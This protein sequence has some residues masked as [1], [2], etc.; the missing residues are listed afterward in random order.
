MMYPFVRPAYMKLTVDQ[1]KELC[2]FAYQACSVINQWSVTTRQKIIGFLDKIMVMS[3]AFTD[4]LGRA[5]ADIV[6]NNPLEFTPSAII[7]FVRTYLEQFFT[8][9]DKKLCLPR[10][11]KELPINQPPLQEES[12]STATISQ[13]THRIRAIVEETWWVVRVKNEYRMCK[14]TFDRGDYWEMV[15]YKDSKVHNPQY[16]FPKHDNRVVFEYKEHLTP[17]MF[18]DK[19]NEAVQ[20]RKAALLQQ[21]HDMLLRF[22]T[23]LIARHPT[24]GTLVGGVEAEDDTNWYLDTYDEHGEHIFYD[25]TRWE[26][27]KKS[28]CTVLQILRRK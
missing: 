7:K 9:R 18:K 15:E 22:D 4:D 19:I 24:G 25:D 11:Q 2:S 26:L 20:S 12:K 16:R 28:R 21:A 17:A 8:I 3:P 6:A 14:L 1:Q 27:D 23:V 13:P 5:Y 10:F